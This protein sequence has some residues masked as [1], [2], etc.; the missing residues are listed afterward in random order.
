M[1]RG[2]LEA[3]LAVEPVRFAVGDEAH[4]SAVGQLLLEEGGDAGHDRLAEPAALMRGLNGDVRHL[5]HEAA[6]ADDPAHADDAAVLAHHDAEDR[7]WK[8]DGRALGAFGAK[9]GHAA[10]PKIVV[11]GR[12]LAAQLVALI[13]DDTSRWD[14]AQV[15]SRPTAGCWAL[16]SW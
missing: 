2:R 7:A 11:G 5:Q 1:R 10:Q 9:A 13:H 8:S 15:L 12:D 14:L 6:I 3:E 16:P 4:V